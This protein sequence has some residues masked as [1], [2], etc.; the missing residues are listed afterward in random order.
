MVTVYRLSLLGQAVDLAVHLQ[1]FKSE[2][3]TAF[4]LINDDHHAQL[5]APSKFGA[6]IN[7]LS[8]GDEKLPLTDLDEMCRVH[9]ISLPCF[10]GKVEMK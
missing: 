10:Q 5:I 4:L 1:W 3:P 2:E 7:V 8:D 9:D 6:Y